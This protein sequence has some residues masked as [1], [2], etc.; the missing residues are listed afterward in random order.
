M[1]STFN[2]LW[3]QTLPTRPA[4]N[5]IWKHYP[6]KLWHPLASNKETLCHLLQNSLPLSARLPLCVAS[7][8][9]VCRPC[10]S[11]LWADGAALLSSTCLLND[12]NY[13]PGLQATHAC[14]IS[15]STSPICMAMHGTN[16]SRVE[17]KDFI[18]PHTILWVPTG[19]HCLGAILRGPLFDGTRGVCAEA[20]RCC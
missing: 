5:D 12:S 3:L 14:F 8:S 19:L 4:V 11:I 18:S 15:T 10:G 2:F 16:H 7:S 6:N 17:K 13:F 20:D 9:L 1:K